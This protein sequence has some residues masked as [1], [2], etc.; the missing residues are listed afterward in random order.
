MCVCA[1]VRLT[2]R[3]AMIAIAGILVGE[4]QSG[5]ATPVQVGHSLT[6]SLAHAR[7]HALTQ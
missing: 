2:G 5:G 3:L 4:Y 1:R 7:T 6:H